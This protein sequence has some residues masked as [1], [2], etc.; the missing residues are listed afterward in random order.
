M[1][2]TITSLKTR[3]VLVPMTRP[4]QTSTGSITKVPF[5]LVDLATSTGAVGRG[6]LFCI[7]PLALKA[8]VAMLGD[9][10]SLVVGQ[11]LVPYEIGQMLEKRFILLGNTGILAMAMAGIDMAA[12]DAL[13][14]EAGVPL[15]EALGGAVRPVQAYNS[16]GL[17]LMGPE[18]LARDVAELLA[19][20][21]SAVKLR[22]GYATLAEDIAALHAVKGAVPAEVLVMSDYNQAL[23]PTEAIRRGLALDGLG[24][25]WIEEP[26]DAFD[27][28]GNARVAAALRTPVQIGENYWGPR[29][30]ARAIAAAASDYVMPDLMRIGGVSGWMRAAALAHAAALPM[31]SH[32]FP[33]FSA[34]LMCVTPT[35]HWLEYVDWANPL[36][37]DPLEIRAGHAQVRA[38]PGA[39]IEW[40]EVAVAKYTIA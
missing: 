32:L 37:R 33:E 21:F 1:P 38:V 30:M 9:L 23:D 5:V 27:H 3:A 2:S 17:G 11:P 7:T 20:G 13:A 35:A 19:G 14:I 15:A 34:H 25:A 31:S 26:V 29:D 8:T 39:G 28:A 40:D 16:C 18:R 12:W 4:L 36:L 10:A 6:Y 24:L 22:L